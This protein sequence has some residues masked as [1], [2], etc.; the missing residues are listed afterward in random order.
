MCKLKC[1]NGKNGCE[2]CESKT[3]CKKCEDGTNYIVDGALCKL[4]CVDNQNNCGKCKDDSTCEKCTDEIYTVD[5][6][7]CKLKPCPSSCSTCTKFNYCRSCVNYL[8]PIDGR[9]PTCMELHNG[10]DEICSNEEC[11]S[12]LKFFEPLS[13]KKCSEKKSYP[14]PS[15]KLIDCGDF[16]KID[17]KVR[18]KIYLR[19][20][21]GMMFNGVISFNIVDMDSTNRR[22]SQPAA[23][24][25]IQDGV[26]QGSYSAN[27]YGSNYFAKFD[28]ES[29]NEVS[30]S[31]FKITDLKLINYNGEENP[32][33]LEF[34]YNSLSEKDVSTC[35]TTNIEDKYKDIIYYVFIQ[36]GI[37][38]KTNSLLLNFNN[39]RL[40]TD[41]STCFLS[42]NKVNINVEGTIERDESIIDTFSIHTDDGNKADCTVKKDA[43]TTD[44][45]LECVVEDPIEGFTLKEEES[46]SENGNI[47]YVTTIN[48]NSPAPNCNKIVSGVTGSK[49]SSSG[50]GLSGGAIA[51][52]VIGCVAVVAIAGFVL[53]FFI[54]GAG[55][56]GGVSSVAQSYAGTTT[57]SIA[58]ENTGG[59]KK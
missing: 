51:G 4:K 23:G 30:F 13:N 16:K 7:S 46:K 19:L 14:T 1:E 8:S 43:K 52:V 2:E 47:F 6:S 45:N 21:K 55:L 40:L 27:S 37:Q 48:N 17:E 36:K 10:C 31:H 26:A 50:K 44:A 33:S 57:S 59:L 56:L 58:S 9:C 54:K 15:L 22:L 28:C 49:G 5:D 38:T 41:S 12:C 18:F 35:T 3:L 20:D 24:K 25:C 11:Y 53:F 32:D 29:D 34:G 42:D 39:K